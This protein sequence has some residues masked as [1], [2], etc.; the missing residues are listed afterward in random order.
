M[1]IVQ[2][3]A[4]YIAVDDLA[5]VTTYFNPSR[6]R[7]K[8]ENYRRFRQ[9]FVQSNQDLVTVE[10][11]F[12]DSEF[13]LESTQKH[14]VIRIRADSVLWQKER[15]LNLA[16]QALP[17]S[18]TKVA[19]LD[20][21]LLFS[22]PSWLLETS[23]A[24]EECRLVQPFE[25]VVRLPMGFHVYSGDGLVYRSFAAVY[26]AHP[27][28][29]LCGNFD[30]HG[31][32]GFAWAA[33]RDLLS[34]IGFYDACIAG[35]GDHMM[36]HDA[37]GDWQSS[38]VRRDVG[39]TETQ[40]N[41][42]RNWAEPFGTAVDGKLHSVAGTV[43]HLWHGEIQHRRYADRHAELAGFSF[44]PVAD[45]AI[46]S[47]GAWKWNSN[48]PELHRWARQY[49]DHRLEDGVAFPTDAAR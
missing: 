13:S 35:S 43:L 40:A 11:A 18:F 12:S 47:S 2:G 23:R 36:A 39:R 14:P 25:A 26:R 5:V 1:T 10:L 45:I 49:F 20:C 32:T 17:P 34:S 3:A 30:I 7:T 4:D 16:L 42:F 27:T 44:D 9:P 22:N 24:L 46:D 15:L 31:H 37:C 33:R 29:H 48:K 28:A 38:C 6:Y 21:D 19:W 8:L 41:H